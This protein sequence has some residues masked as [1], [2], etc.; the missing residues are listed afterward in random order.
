MGRAGGLGDADDDGLGDNPG[1]GSSLSSNVGDN[2]LADPSRIFDQ[3]AQP[4]VEPLPGLQARGNFRK[5]Q[6]GSDQTQ[7]MPP[8]QT[9]PLVTGA[10]RAKT[11]YL[12]S[13]LAA[14]FQNTNIT[15]SPP[16]HIAPNLWST[17]IDLSGTVVVPL[18][19]GAPI[20]VLSYRA[21]PGR[22]ARISGY[23]LDVS[24][25]ANYPYDGSLVWTI[26]KN[27][28]PVQTLQNFAEHRGT[29]IQPRDT[30]VLLWGD[31]GSA[32]GSGDLI[33]FSVQRA[34]AAMA[35]ATVSMALTGWTW[36]PRTNQ[37]G[38]KAS[39]GAF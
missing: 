15:A 19:A 30:F 16:A 36:R 38:T 29:V 9:K 2:S 39:V 14:L 26:S 34:V 24:L 6:E 37:E 28:L 20:V 22:W 10:D 25:P 27:G 1:E 12:L 35:D 32:Q 17:P 11:A 21:Q 13:Q 8:G 33:T 18:A 31:N 5:F 3:S 4:A 23:G 7:G